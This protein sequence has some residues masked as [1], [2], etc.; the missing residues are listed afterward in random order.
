MDLFVSSTETFPANDILKAQES[1]VFCMFI[2]QTYTLKN[3]VFFKFFK[4]NKNIAPRA[5]TLIYEFTINN[6]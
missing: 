1:R 3:S 5:L 4:Y 6:H 2:Q